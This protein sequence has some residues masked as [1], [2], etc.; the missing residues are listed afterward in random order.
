MGG[1]EG[2]GIWSCVSEVVTFVVHLTRKSKHIIQMFAVHPFLFFSHSLR[3][4][5]CD[6][7]ACASKMLSIVTWYMD[8]LLK[9]NVNYHSKAWTWNGNDSNHIVIVE[10]FGALPFVFVIH[11]QWCWIPLHYVPI[12][13]YTILPFWKFILIPSYLIFQYL[14][15]KKGLNSICCKLYG[16]LWIQ[17]GI[18]IYVRRYILYTRYSLRISFDSLKFIYC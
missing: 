7:Q 8:G 2:V 11:Y 12:I 18:K 15:I 17:V 14:F 9:D 13:S 16:K 10:K 3:D 4:H 1:L 5:F 6:I